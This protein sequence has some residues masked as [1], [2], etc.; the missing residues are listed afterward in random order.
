MPKEQFFHKESNQLL[1]LMDRAAQRSRGSR[2]QV[3]EDFLEIGICTLS[4]GQMEEQYL[5]IV[6]RYVEGEP[7]K[8]AID[9]LAEMF[10]RLVAVMEETRSDILGDLFMGSI[11]YGEHGQFYT[12]ESVTDLMAQ[13]VNHDEPAGETVSDPCCGSGRMLLSAAKLN[14]NRRFYGQDIDIRCVRMTAINL[15]LHNLYGQV[16]WGNSLTK[17]KLLAYQTGF[18]GK[19]FIREV[20]IVVKPEPIPAVPEIVQEP[21]Q[22]AELKQLNLF[23]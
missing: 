5:K 10:G 2:S 19:G 11:T 20:P 21:S 6:K 13:I 7:G 15:A 22:S 16:V 18:D 9:I 17:E 1:D 12:P 3:F 8:R 4:G 14:P 23:E